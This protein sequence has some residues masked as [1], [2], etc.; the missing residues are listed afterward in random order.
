MKK[1]LFLVLTIILFSKEVNAQKDPNI[2]LSVFYKGESEKINNENSSA[3]YNAI[4]GMFENYNTI[5]AKVNF[6]K[7]DEKEVFFKSN[8]SNEKLI[9][10]I[11]SLSKN[12][13]LSLITQFNKQQLVLESNFPSFF[14]K[15]NDLDFVKIK[16]KSFDAVNENK[17]K[18]LID[19]IHTTSEN[20]G[21]LSDKSLIYHTIKFQDNIN[22]SS[23]KAKGNAT[24]NV[25]ILT[26]YSIQKLN[27]SNLITTFSI[28]EKE[29]KIVE[30]YNNLFVFDVLNESSEFN[31]KAENFNYWALDLNNKN[32]IKLGSNMSYL[33]YK[34][35]YNIFKLNKKITKEEL[36]KLLPVNKLQK[37]KENGFYNVI[38]HDFAFDNNILFYSKIYGISKDIKVKI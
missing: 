26:D 6:K 20:G 25:K 32:E 14:Q 27:K 17:K 24:Y 3:I 16:L 35:L 13:K 5:S 21:T 9:S 30:I 22:I 34:D 8:L 10:S 4:Y 38:E 7:F 11:D 19:S 37:M 28:N 2:M 31:K 15:N 1:R 12:S 18:I 36:K 33:I 23:K 29:I